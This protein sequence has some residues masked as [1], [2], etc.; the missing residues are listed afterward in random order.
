MALYRLV[1]LRVS[2]DAQ[3]TEVQQACFDEIGYDEIFSEKISGTRSDRP[4]FLALVERAIELRKRQHDVVVYV[5]EWTRFARNTAVALNVLNDLE[6][7]GCKV[8]EATTQQLVTLTTS[9]GFLSAGMKSI[10]A[11]HF[12]RQLSDRLTRVHAHRR[13]LHKPHGFPPFG[14]QLSADKSQFEPGPEW[15]IARAVVDRFLDGQPLR[16]IAAWTANEHGIN[17]SRRTWNR[18]LANPVLRGHLNY[19]KSGGGMVYN[20]HQALI[21]EKEWQQIERQQTTNRQLRGNNAKRIHAVPTGPV[22]CSIC[23]IP[24]EVYFGAR[25]KNGSTRRY[26][27]CRN[28]KNKTPHDCPDHSCRDDWVEAAIQNAIQEQ[29]E[30]IIDQHMQPQGGTDPRLIPKALELEQL[31]RLEHV[32]GVSDAIAGLE[33]EIEQI[34]TASE[35]ET[36]NAKE[37]EQMIVDL[38]GLMPGDWAQLS[39]EERRN[40]YTYLVREV[41]VL[42]AEVVNVALW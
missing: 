23:R 5:H 38:A 2:T 18:W 25:R 30:R 12:S 37:R 36:V 17:R 40:L 41:T 35:V 42:G 31:R 29:A 16:A 24:C 39:V 34:K 20:S 26:F 32:P 4:E 10:M 14:Y 15:E 1:Y 6:A 8:M 28:R 11:E 33:L 19:H 21:T 13:S 9:D 22:I 3:N 7:A 27:V